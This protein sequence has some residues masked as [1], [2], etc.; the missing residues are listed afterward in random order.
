M[1]NHWFPS[2]SLSSI[3]MAQNCSYNVMGRGGQ[4]EQTGTCGFRVN[5][6][7][8]IVILTVIRGDY[9]KYLAEVN[10]FQHKISGLN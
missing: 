10:T 7:N 2:R 4:L 3:L 6:G 9:F 8:A 1:E 5:T